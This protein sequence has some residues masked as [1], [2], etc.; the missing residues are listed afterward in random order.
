MNCF[1]F[2]IFQSNKSPEQTSEMISSNS[3]HK[4]EKSPSIGIKCDDDHCVIPI[5]LLD[6]P[7]SPCSP[8]SPDSPCSPDSPYSDQPDYK[9]ELERL[10]QEMTLMVPRKTENGYYCYIPNEIQTDDLID[11]LVV[12]PIIPDIQIPGINL[13]PTPSAPPISPHSYNYQNIGYTDLYQTP[14]GMAPDSKNIFYGYDTN[15]G[16]N[17]SRLNRP[18]TYR[19]ENHKITSQVA[20]SHLSH[21]NRMKTR[22]LSNP[23]IMS[24]NRTHSNPQMNYQSNSRNPNSRNPNSRN[25]NSRNPNT[26]LNLHVNSQPTRPTRPTQPTRPTR[27]VQTNRY[28]FDSSGKPITITESA[29]SHSSFQCR[30][31]QARSCCNALF[32]CSVSILSGKS[33]IR[34][35]SCL[36]FLIIFFISMLSLLNLPV[37]CYTLLA[38]DES[39]EYCKTEITPSSIK[40]LMVSTL[41]MWFTS[42]LCVVYICSFYG[43]NA[44]ETGVLRAEIRR[45]RTHNENRQLDQRLDDVK[46]SMQIEN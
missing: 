29:E 35:F 42:T 30:C 46:H 25:P 27:R 37:S 23:H 40:Y 3:E 31:I 38:E 17:R 20:N 5:Q 33:L 8:D 44:D 43:T 26:Q 9:T 19:D 41:S 15:H 39:S 14:T 10:K 13:L 1:A 6:S 21:S 32:K 36:G 7:D 22:K 45:L 16:N 34:I 24:K 12:V 28:T 18:V 2:S 4:G 11:R